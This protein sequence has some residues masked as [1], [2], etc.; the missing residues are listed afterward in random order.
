MPEP[1][2]EEKPHTRWQ[3]LFCQRPRWYLLWVPVGGVLMFAFGIVVWGG[4]NTV[5]DA[6]NTEAFCISCHEMHDYVYLEYKETIH[7]ANRTG[8]KASC[9]D[10]H[11][12]R[13]YIYKLAR[14]VR[15]S[16]ELL[17]KVLGTISTR[18]KFEAHRLQLAESVWKTMKATDS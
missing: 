13:P 18:E 5:L 6:T 17:H 10:C 7:F 8:V 2:P 4:F 1:T 3:A 12:P 9:P 15:A 11:V 16:N 14:K